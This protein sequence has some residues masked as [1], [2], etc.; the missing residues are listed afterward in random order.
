MLL[1]AYSNTFAKKYG[2]NGDR[3]SLDFIALQQSNYFVSADLTA[4]IYRVTRFVWV[5]SIL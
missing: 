5:D 3:D 1:S 2:K 4:S